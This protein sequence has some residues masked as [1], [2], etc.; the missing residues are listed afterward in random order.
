MPCCFSIESTANCVRGNR[1]LTSTCVT[2]VQFWLHVAI[3]LGI[4]LAPVKGRSTYPDI[5]P[6]FHTQPPKL[7][8]ARLDQKCRTLLNRSC[9]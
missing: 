3:G 4:S 5:N 1:T 8:G 2:I 9:I 7:P 6:M